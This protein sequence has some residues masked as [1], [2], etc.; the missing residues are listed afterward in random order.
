MVADSGT[1]GLT[2]LV[3]GNEIAQSLQGKTLN[4]AALSLIDLANQRG[5][6]DNITTVLLGLPFDKKQHKPGWLMG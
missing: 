5:G 4:Q 6:H 3:N 2:D 1:D